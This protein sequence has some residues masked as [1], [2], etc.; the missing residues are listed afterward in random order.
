MK[1]KTGSKFHSQ[2]GLV[3]KKVLLILAIVGAFAAWAIHK[4]YFKWKGPKP[5]EVAEEMK[6]DISATAEKL[7]K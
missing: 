4:G 6:S 3:I 7:T 1:I 2:K 5:A